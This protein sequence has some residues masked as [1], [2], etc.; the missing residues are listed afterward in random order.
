MS[1]KGIL[2]RVG[3][4]LGIVV[5]SLVFVY[6]TKRDV[7][8]TTTKVDSKITAI[9]F[10]GEATPLYDSEVAERLDREIVTNRNYHSSTTLIIKRANRVF[11]VIEPI[12]KEYGVPDDFKY[13]A[14]A[15]SALVNA[16]SRAGARGV[17]QF[18]PQT[19]KEKGLIVNS[20][21]DERYH[22]VKSTQAACKYLLE[23]K[24]KFG[25]WT[26]AAA[27]YNAGLAGVQKQLDRQEVENYYDLLLNE[28]TSRYVFRILALKEIIE[29][30]SKYNFNFPEEELYALIPTKKIKVDASISN[31][32]DFAKQHAINYK[33]LKTHN[34]WLR[35]K[36][37]KVYAG[38]EFYIEIPTEGYNK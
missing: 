10:A 1:K 38:Q 37:L 7:I 26:L 21:V 15:E 22:L 35:D 30:P 9:N 20:F 11:P 18:M 31:L 12:L 4:S 32:V 23:A 16:V 27:S 5:L 6:A 33:I 2:K 25:T 17:W 24:E 13:L 8:T 19:A 36:E 29:N 28:E 34:P 14:V 3:L